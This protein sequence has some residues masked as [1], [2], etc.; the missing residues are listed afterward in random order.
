MSLPTS[1]QYLDNGYIYG[2]GYK[3]NEKIRHPFGSPTHY[4]FSFIPSFNFTCADLTPNTFHK[5]EMWRIVS[6]DGQAVNQSTYPF[7]YSNIT[8]SGGNYKFDIAT[9]SD[10][11]GEISG[12]LSP[13]NNNSYFYYVAYNQ[14]YYIPTNDTWQD[15]GGLPDPNNVMAQRVEAAGGRT[16]METPWG[17]RDMLPVKQQ[18]KYYLR[19]KL[20]NGVTVF[21]TV[22][23]AEF[24]LAVDV[25][26]SGFV[27]PLANNTIYIPVDLNQPAQF[28]TPVL[29]R[30]C[31]QPVDSEPFG[32]TD[33]IKRDFVTADTRNLHIHTLEIFCEDDPQNETYFLCNDTQSHELTVDGVE[34]TFQA[35]NFSF[36]LP[37][38]TE[39][40]TPEMQL[41]ISNVDGVAGE[42][43]ERVRGLGRISVRYRVYLASD[44]TQPQ[45]PNPLTL[46]LTEANIDMFQ[47][48]GRLS[49]TDS[50]DVRFPAE[51]YN[52]KNFPN[53]FG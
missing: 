3:T 45:N 48:S 10:S 4:I 14:D 32:Y 39:D 19:V 46:F 42:Y 37:Q 34:Q 27:S 47:I 36:S 1:L 12:V 22:V 13:S 9:T 8:L 40:S 52:V 11:S 43:V 51:N 23:T 6:I 28:W 20:G 35:A 44:P 2:Y 30:R 50:L 31:N 33:L 16:I 15:A 29:D 18:V 41:T 25:N 26:R 49:L 38:T 21:S 53:I 5:V 17:E 7:T 24:G